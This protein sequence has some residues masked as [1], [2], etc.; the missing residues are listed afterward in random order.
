MDT[1]TSESTFFVEQEEAFNLIHIIS[2]LSISIEDINTSSTQQQQSPTPQEALSKLRCIL[3][4]YLECPT[5]LDPYLET[6][7]QKLSLPARSIVHELYLSLATT[8]D[9]EE[10]ECCTPNNNNDVAYRT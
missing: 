9:V 2:S 5:L 1:A 8:T 3:D 6:M 10:G 4:R 7:V